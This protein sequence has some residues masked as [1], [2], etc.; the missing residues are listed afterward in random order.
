MSIII[1]DIPIWESDSMV[2]AAQLY[3]ESL[4]LILNLM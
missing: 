1:M 2:V 3:N 4:L